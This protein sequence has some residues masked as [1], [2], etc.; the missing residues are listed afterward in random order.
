MV[1]AFG[2]GIYYTGRRTFFWLMLLWVNLLGLVLTV[3]RGSLMALLLAGFLVLTLK[4][5]FAKIIVLSMAIAIVGILS[6]TYPHWISV[7]KPNGWADVAVGTVSSGDAN[8]LDRLLY[9][10]PRAVDLFLRSPLIGTGFGSYDDLP[11]RFIG[12]P[13]VFSYNNPVELTFSAAHAHNSY[14]H[15]LAETGLVGFAL[16]MSMLFAVRK[17]IDT[18]TSRSVRLGLLIGLWVTIFSSVT[19]HRMFTPSQMLPFTIIYGLA[20]A[21]TRWAKRRSGR[22]APM[23]SPHGGDTNPQASAGSVG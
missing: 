13:Y 22:Q 15:I 4:E 16:T 21:N 5:R 7:G 1:T 14:L 11:Y 17:E 3:S 12:I 6:Y 9:L 18:V 10:W 20:V 2:L 19:E 8:I 23:A